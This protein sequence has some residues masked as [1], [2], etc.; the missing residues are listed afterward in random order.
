MLTGIVH[1][2][3]DLPSESFLYILNEL[4]DLGAGIDVTLERLDLDA[5]LGRELSGD[6][7]SIGRGVCYG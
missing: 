1:P 5:M 3:I 7:G 4:V 6:G 2:D